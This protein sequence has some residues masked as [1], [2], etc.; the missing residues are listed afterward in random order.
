M[1]TKKPRAEIQPQA[2]Q[3]SDGKTALGGALGRGILVLSSF[4]TAE[5]DLSAKEL[6]ERTGLPKATL[7][8]VLANLRELGIIKY[9]ERR[10]R[11]RPSPTVLALG[12][13]VLAGMTIRQLARPL[14]QELA[15]HFECQ[16]S[17]AVGDGGDFLYVELVQG[18]GSRVYRPEVGT[19]ASLT[20]SASG[21]AYLTLLEPDEREQFVERLS[22]G[23][24]ERK[25][26]LMEKLA[27]TEVE[28]R[29]VG[30]CRN[31]GELARDIVGAAVPLRSDPSEDQL[32]VLG[33]SLPAYRLSQ[34]P[35]LLDDV[36][37]R[38]VALVRNVEVALGR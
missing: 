22:H 17:L 37:M 15:D 32:F 8:R 11:F 1:T 30:F 27:E 38:L 12:A 36:G 6:M 24:P 28:L 7:F 21:R 18:R 9:S 13:P 29:D 20:R 4:T 16:V 35:D 23:E 34:Q 19:A 2:K 5:P 33:V 31:M 3:Q 26:W 14:M 25:Q 10:A